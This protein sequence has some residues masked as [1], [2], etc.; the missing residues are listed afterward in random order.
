MKLTDLLSSVAQKAG[1]QPDAE[2]IAEI[3]GND[4]LAA[5]DVP[6]EH[7]KKI[8][9]NLLNLEQAKQH[10]DLK[11]HFRASFL[12]GVDKNLAAGLEDAG[13]SEEDLA[14]IKGQEKTLDKLNSALE[15]LKARKAD[16]KAKA[17]DGQKEKE[18]LARIDELNAEHARSVKALKDEYEGK[19]Q[20]KDT[21]HRQFVLD[22][23][24]GEAINKHKPADGIDQS[25]FG[26]F[27]KMEVNDHLEAQGLALTL[28]DNGAPKVVRKDTQEAALDEKSGQPLDYAT[29]V[30]EVASQ[31]G[32]VARGNGQKGGAP[33]PQPAQNTPYAP[34]GQAEDPRTQAMLG[35][36]RRQD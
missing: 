33:H 6:D 8:S 34:G 23:K 22:G 13:L 16:G 35:N 10:K 2:G 19:L 30:D 1:L 9:D 28:D 20:E 31:S 32:I 36:L 21:Q 7:A 4:Q 18:L 11:A 29:L 5:I 26:R 17:G 3:L 15:K 24:L 14:E 25:K 12:D 27:L